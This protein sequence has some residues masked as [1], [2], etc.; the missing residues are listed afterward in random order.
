M[1]IRRINASEVNLVAG[2]FDKYRVFYDQPSNIDLARNFLQVRLD[3]RESIIFVAFMDNDGVSIP[4]GF[5]QLYP[6]YSSVRVIR[7]WI[8]NDLYVEPSF[9][10]KG[11]GEG[12]IRAA[13]NFAKENGAVFVELSTANDNHTAQSLYEQIGFRKVEPDKDFY[14]YR[15]SV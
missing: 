8:L 1:V 4:A 13:T 14:T 11:I 6:T 9:R 2:M 12:L 7:N 15:I 10:K 5:T 3:N